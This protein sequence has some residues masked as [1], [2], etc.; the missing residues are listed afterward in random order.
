MKRKE[1]TNVCVGDGVERKPMQRPALRTAAS[2]GSRVPGGGH[3]SLLVAMTSLEH[4]KR[5]LSVRS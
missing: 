3:L 5:T 4:R 1:I 2:L